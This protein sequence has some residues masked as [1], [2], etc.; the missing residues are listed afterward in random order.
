MISH[1]IVQ[2]LVRRLWIRHGRRAAQKDAIVTFCLV[3]SW[4]ITALSV[5]FNERF[6]YEYPGDWWRVLFFLLATGI[7]V[8]MMIGEVREYR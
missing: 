1:A 2:K 8:F 3:F 7:T 5:P 6:Y 4:T